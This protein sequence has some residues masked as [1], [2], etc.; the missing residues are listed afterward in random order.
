MEVK[1]NLQVKVM[2]EKEKSKLRFR[3]FINPHIDK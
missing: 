2:S 3:H 1:F